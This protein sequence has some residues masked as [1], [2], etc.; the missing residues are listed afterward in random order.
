MM[1]RFENP[2]ISEL[3]IGA[4]FNPPLIAL[5]NEHIGLFWSRI[6]DQF[7]S[8]EQKQPVAATQAIVQ[9]ADE[10]FPMPRFWF[11]SEDE[12]HLIQ[13]QKD[14]FILNW[15]RRNASYPQFA[16]N[17]KPTFDRYFGTFEDFAKTAAGVD[18]LK[19]DLC[20]LTYVNVVEPCDYWQGPQDTANVLP[21]F[22]LPE[23]P[24]ARIG[25]PAFNCTYIHTIDSDLQLHFVVR[26]ATKADQPET[27][28]LVFD[29]RATGRLRGVSKSIA[30]AWYMRAHDAIKECFLLSTNKEIQDNYWKPLSAAS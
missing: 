6:V 11:I 22:T 2:P 27:P 29:I 14:A 25:S 1:I 9:T 18:D 4:Y 16:Q 19:I 3:V 15:R 23:Y 28:L 20:E 26:S 8:V 10:A 12:S 30:D 13:V 17:V 5:R 7:G 24:A 21:S